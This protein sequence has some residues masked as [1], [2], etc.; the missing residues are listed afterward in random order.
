MGLTR[1][2]GGIRTAVPGPAAVPGLAT[3]M[4]EIRTDHE[5]G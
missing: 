2:T 4:A 1:S 3:A 5:D